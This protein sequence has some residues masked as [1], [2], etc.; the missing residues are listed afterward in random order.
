MSKSFSDMY[1]EVHK[2][3]GET[4]N[5]LNEQ[6]RK[7]TKKIVTIAVVIYIPILVFLITTFYANVT[8]IF[9]ASF[10]YFII[11]LILTKLLTFKTSVAANTYYKDN[12]VQDVIKGVFDNSDFQPNIGIGRS[13]YNSKAFLDHYDRFHS[14]DLVTTNNKYNLVFSDVHTE[15]ERTDDE[16][17]TYYVTSFL[18]LAGFCDIA[19]PINT[20]LLIVNNRLLGSKNKS[21]VKVDMPEFEKVFDVYA[22]NKIIAMQL[23]TSDVMTDILDLKNRYK[24]MMEI[25]IENGKIYFRIH[26]GNNFEMANTKNIMKVEEI[27]KHFDT[28]MLVERITNKINGYIAELNI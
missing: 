16:G 28:L 8:V 17:H 26:N 18:G 9:F 6:H 11:S 19:K 10:W 2:K 4:A 21:N 13:E 20:N 1:N 27:Q 7:A 3:Y 15:D 5:M 14:S 23:L 24:S 25:A 12:I 22:E